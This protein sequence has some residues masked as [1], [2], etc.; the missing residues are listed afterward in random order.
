LVVKIQNF[1]FEILNDQSSFDLITNQDEVFVDNKFFIILYCTLYALFLRKVPKQFFKYLSKNFIQN[2]F[3]ASLFGFTEK[4][5]TEKCDEGTG[6]SLC[7]RADISKVTAHERIQ[8]L[9]LHKL[10]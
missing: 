8:H 7:L 4:I 10:Q 9:Y 6:L 2:G 1:F 3:R 5:I